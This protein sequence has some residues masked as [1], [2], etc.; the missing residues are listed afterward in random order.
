[1]PYDLC[2]LNEQAEQKELTQ[3]QGKPFAIGAGFDALSFKHT[4]YAG[5]MDPLIMVDHFTMTTPTFGPHAHAGLSAVSILFEDSEGIF[6]NKDSLGNDIDL[7]PGDL[8]WLK[9]GRGAVHDEK[10]RTGA[11]THAMQVFVNLPARMKYDAP[12]SLHVKATNM[13]VL[14]GEGYSARLVLGESNGTK[15]TK[16]PALPMTIL[17]VKLERGASFAHQVPAGQSAWVLA[18]DGA[19]GVR[20]GDAEA[21]LKP[22]ASVSIRAQDQAQSL[23]TTG[24]T[25]AHFVILQAEPLREP[26]VQRGPFAMTTEAEV[27][28]MFAAHAAGELGS[29]DDL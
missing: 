11:R 20:N 27:E 19:I 21:S 13:P 3:V 9:A 5:A 2:N 12:D 22:G 6:N 26:F 8:Y 17:D 25:K 4:M 18:V 1:M 7:M 28:A 10:P 24:S 23:I 15:G 16:S 14:V 29:I